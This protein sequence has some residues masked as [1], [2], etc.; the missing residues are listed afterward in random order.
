MT[1]PFGSTQ[2]ISGRA[3]RTQVDGLNEE[4][5]LDTALD[6]S[7]L[8]DLARQEFKE[9][10]DVNTV[11]ARYGVGGMKRQPEYS[12]LDY[13]MDLQQSLMAIREAERAIE[14]LPPELAEKYSTWERLLAGA[15]SGNFKTDLD[16]YQ[17]AKEA[18][19]KAALDAKAAAAAPSP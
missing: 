15:Y 6:C 11:L 3:I 7:I 5:S 9:E 4:Y 19:D 1:T 8:P 10:T 16:S 14:K 18:S 13:D 17:A 12:E 2:I